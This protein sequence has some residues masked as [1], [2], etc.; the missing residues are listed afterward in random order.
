VK[1][2]NLNKHQRHVF[3]VENNEFLVKMYRSIFGAM[4]FGVIHAASRTDA[5]RL[6]AH[7]SPDL[8]IVDDGLPDGSGVDTTREIRASE[9][10]A[11]IP[12]IAT[13][14]HTSQQAVGEL[15]AAG[16]ASV[17]TK[18]LQV[19]SFSALAKQYLGRPGLRRPV[20]AITGHEAA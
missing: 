2:D 15:H 1:I 7:S 4:G 9:A 18:P 19:N 5:V 8:F 10:F 13:V 16:I 3:I 17:V 6:F 20:E 12:I 11:H 14:S